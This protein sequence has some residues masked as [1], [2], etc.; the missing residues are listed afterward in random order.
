MFFTPVGAT[1]DSNIL[2]F[3]PLLKFIFSKSGERDALI[4]IADDGGDVDEHV[5]TE[6]S[7]ST[8]RRRRGRGGSQRRLRGTKKS[9]PAERSLNFV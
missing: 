9:P 3:V 7:A 8:G 1:V 5:M 2:F 6:V 4:S